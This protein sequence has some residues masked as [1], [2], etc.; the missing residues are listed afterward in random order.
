MLADR[1]LPQLRQEL[2]DIAAL[3]P[4][5]VLVAAIAAARAHKLGQRVPQRTIE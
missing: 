5:D 2:A 4:R 1:T 3:Y